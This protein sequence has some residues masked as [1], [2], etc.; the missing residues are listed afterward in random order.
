MQKWVVLLVNIIA[1]LGVIFNH[2]HLDFSAGHF[3]ADASLSILVV[4]M[5]LSYLLC[6]VSIK[7]LL[8]GVNDYENK[9][10]PS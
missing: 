3:V 5:V 10:E 9:I 6:N 8:A 1:L 2:L 4:S 7:K